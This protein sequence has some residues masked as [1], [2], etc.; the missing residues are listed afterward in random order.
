[1]EILSYESKDMLPG[2]MLDKQTE[3]FQIFG[4]SC[5]EDAVEFY[6]PIFDWFDQYAENPLKSTTMDFKMTYFNTISAKVILMIMT[7]L[8]DL[9]NSGKDV[10]IRWF[11]T[12]GDEDQEE[13]GEEFMNIVDLKFE[14]IPVENVTDQSIDEEDFDDFMDEFI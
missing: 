10:K 2:I 8:E 11:Y 3:T 9:S 14:C 13:A 4:Q 12:E 6:E 7:K 5:P 1:M